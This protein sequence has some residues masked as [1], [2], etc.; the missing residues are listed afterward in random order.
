MNNKLTDKQLIFASEYL[1]DFN[2]TRAYKEAYK[3]VKSDDVAAVNGN[4]LLRNAKVKS[5]VDEHIK[6]IEDNNIA[7]AKEVMQ[8]LTKVMRG[9]ETEEVVVT[10]NIGD[11]M[12]EART[13]KKDI[14]AKDRL[15]AAELLGK[16]FKLFVDKQE[17]EHSGEVTQNVKA[18]IDLT[19]LDDKD[20]EKLEEIAAKLEE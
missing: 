15:K 1:K 18:S 13:V 19:K 17:V 10:E 14:S 11:Y 3:K 2:A 8:Y 7:D 16:R 20:L 12:S 6:A 4:R 5:Y 9:E